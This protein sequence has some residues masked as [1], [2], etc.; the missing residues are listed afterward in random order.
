[1]LHV[2]LSQSCPRSS[3]GTG[4]SPRSELINARL[5]E[6][7]LNSMNVTCL[8]SSPSSP[9]VRLQRGTGAPLFSP[10]QGSQASTQ[11]KPQERSAK[12]PRP[13]VRSRW[14]LDRAESDVKDAEADFHE[15]STAPSNAPSPAQESTTLA[16]R[17]VA[18]HGRASTWYG[19]V[20]VCQ[21]ALLRLFCRSHSIRTWRTSPKS[22]ARRRCP[23]P[24]RHTSDAPPPPAAPRTDLYLDASSRIMVI[25]PQP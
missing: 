22:S 21:P 6:S 1:M 4:L 2:A 9:D 18:T 25:C 8:H 7:D 19:C 23:K 10:E 3:G 15:P 16:P 11:P 14:S 17:P 20:P 24:S 5:S 13:S 12:T